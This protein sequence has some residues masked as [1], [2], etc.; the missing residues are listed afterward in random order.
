MTS[1]AGQHV[2]KNLIISFSCPSFAPP[3]VTQVADDVIESVD[4]KNAR[5]FVQAIDKRH[6]MT[7]LMSNCCDSDTV[8]HYAAFSDY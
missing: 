1:D 6:T 3:S 7:T 2:L 4:K 8:A 5:T